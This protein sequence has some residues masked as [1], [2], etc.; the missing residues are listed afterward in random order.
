MMEKA[1]ARANM[2]DEEIEN[3]NIKE[4][5]SDDRENKI[6]SR[7]KYKDHQN[8]KEQVHWSENLSRKY[9]RLSYDPLVNV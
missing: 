6:H 3:E 1:K 7:S 5:K 4:R 2:I 8:L 9:N